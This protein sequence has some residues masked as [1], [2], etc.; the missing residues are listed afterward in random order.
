M[1][2][3]T[4]A[5]LGLVLCF[6]LALSACTTDSPEPT[7]NDGNG[8]DLPPTDSVNGT[9]ETYTVDFSSS[10]TG[11][12]RLNTGTPG[13]DKD[14]SMAI[15]DLN[16][17]GALQLNAPNGDTLRLGI[18]ADSLL[19][20]RVI[21]VVNVAIGI[22]AE[23]PEDVYPF[24]IS[25]NVNGKSWLYMEHNETNQAALTLEEPFTA[26]GENILEFTASPFAPASLYITSIIFFDASNTAIPVNTDAGWAG[27]A[28]YGEALDLPTI[29]VLDRFEPDMS[30]SNSTSVRYK[31][32]IAHLIGEHS[33]LHI[34]YTSESDNS[35]AIVIKSPPSWWM[36]FQTVS[37]DPQW[38]YEEDEEGL[39]VDNRYYL[40]VSAADFQNNSETRDALCP[41]AGRLCIPAEN[42]C[43][44]ASADEK[45]ILITNWATTFEI[46]SFVIENARG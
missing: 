43:C 5:L 21:D 6:A 28:A 8:G 1:K 9:E 7:G 38:T 25:G 42:P 4:L 15:A 46:E 39:A 17:A 30:E 32:P 34:T 16:G 31:F 45:G 11:F 18:S 19:G 41:L 14:S 27:P 22:D 12:L 24:S 20:A 13:T 3:K 37:G 23:F 2:R 35:P 26:A 29:D 33:V 44:A 40:T 10:N 36:Q